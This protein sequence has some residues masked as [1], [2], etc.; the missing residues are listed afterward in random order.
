PSRTTPGST[1][2]R[3]AA[4]AGSPPRS[5][6]TR[7]SG[8]TRTSTATAATRGTSRGWT[9][10]TSAS[11]TCSRWR[12]A[13]TSRSSGTTGSTGLDEVWERRRVHVVEGVSKLSQYAFGKRVIFIDKEA[14]GI[15]YS[16]MYDRGGEL[17]KIWINDV[18]IRQKILDA[19]GAVEYPDERIFAPAIVM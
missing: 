10:A 8:R 1:C 7:S 6:R 17:W 15:P 11:G 5:A 14:W 19:P 18:M 9:G 12:T 13:G 4:C 16:D 3:C 2:R